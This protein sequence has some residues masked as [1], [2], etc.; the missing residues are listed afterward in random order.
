ML[1]TLLLS[2]LLLPPTQA[3]DT[4]PLSDWFGF[5]GMDVLPIGDDPGP[6]LV[7]DVDGDGLLDIV[8]GNN[9]RS[10]IEVL[11]RRPDSEQLESPGPAKGVN[12]FPDHPD[13]E[14][15]LIPLP[16]QINGIIVHDQIGRAHV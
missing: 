10:R 15:L 11:R 7:A 16:G 13:W 2:S 5:E 1:L 12:E 4:P 6:M 9:R 3:A 14:R 8:V